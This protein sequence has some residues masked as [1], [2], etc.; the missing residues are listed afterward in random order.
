MAFRSPLGR[1]AVS[2]RFGSDRARRIRLLLW[3]FASWLRHGATRLIWGLALV[4]SRSPAR[5]LIA[6][7]DIRTA[8]PTVAT[9]IYAGYFAFDGKAVNT[10]GRSP[11]VIPAPSVAW[12]EAL[13]DF[14]WLRHLRA[15]DT[16]LARVNARALV[17]DWI[18]Q[19]GKPRDVPAWSP[20][21]VARRL[22]SWLNQ[23]PIILEGADGFFYRRFMLSIG[24][25]AV[26]LRRAIFTGLDGEARLVAAIALT[27]LGLCAE[28]YAKLRRQATQVLLEEI[29]VQI[30][31]D[32][33]HVSRNPAVPVELLLYL[34]PLRQAFVAAGVT[35]PAPLLNAVDRMIPMV[36]S[37]RHGD[38]ALALFNGMGVTRPEALATVLAY[39][40]VRGLPISNA[41]YSGYQRMEA[42]EA[43][44]IMDCGKPPPAG[45][46]LG[47]HAGT[48][49]FE[50]SVGAQQVIVNCGAASA[51]PPDMRD[52][53]R[54]SAAHSTLVV[55]DRSSSRFFRGG[56]LEGLIYA[57]PAHVPVT[58]TEQNGDVMV[59]TS[60]D[61]YL[62][63][64]GVIHQR[65]LGLAGGGQRLEGEDRV[66]S[67]TPRRRLGRRRDR[68]AVEFT[69][70]FHLHPSLRIRTIR[71]QTA[72]AIAFPTGELWLFEAG[73]LPIAEEESIYFASPDG[74]RRTDQLVVTGRSSDL[75]VIAWSL[76][77]H[78]EP[79]A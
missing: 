24:R 73:G 23:S 25:H 41:P 33:G 26:F 12:A 66:V 54:S 79:A 76:S 45:F 9:E 18:G 27:E 36:R 14:G 57:G 48:L 52:A 74:A 16:S 34:L 72:V 6:P 56:W 77:R 71:N 53:A 21:I 5:L 64:F 40:D 15:A 60:H 35:V 47:A 49:A 62:S 43:L 59:G 29:A 30:L 32:G 42:Q 4:P 78:E 46:S 67:T 68:Q 7:P 19:A 39:D 65:R 38:G 31:A 2:E 51:G 61:G 10:H 17:G 22:L 58:R 63:R 75:S 70:R 1:P 11:F 20:Q 13:A 50:F 55:A 44:V 3:R 69:V 28:G 37:L 8:D